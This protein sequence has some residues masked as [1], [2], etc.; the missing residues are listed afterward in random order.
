[1]NDIQLTKHFK[2]REFTRSATADQLG[3]DNAPSAEHLKNLT[4]LANTLEEV[5]TLIGS[6]I[7]ISSGYR[8]PELNKAVG[9]VV[10]SDHANGLAADFSAP[11]FGTVEQV[12]KKIANSAIKFDQLIF[13]QTWVHLSIGT[14]MRQQV[15]SLVRGRYVNGIVRS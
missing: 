12:S 13:E 5:R 6:P 4:N 1:M 9:G 11:K 14:R 8:S 3:I 15:L 10:N 2:L 7:I